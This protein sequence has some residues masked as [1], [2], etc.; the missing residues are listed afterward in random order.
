MAPMKLI[1]L[2]TFVAEAMPV[3]YYT[4]NSNCMAK[5]QYDRPIF[6]SYPVDGKMVVLIHPDVISEF[7]EGCK[8]EGITPVETPALVT[9][10]Q[11]VNLKV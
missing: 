4:L 1:S 3:V 9:I 2:L 10:Y 7:L 11:L 8:L 6:I 5:D